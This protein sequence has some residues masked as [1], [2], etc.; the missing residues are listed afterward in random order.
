MRKYM[1]QIMRHQAEKEGFKPSKTVHQLWYHYQ[2]K[3]FNHQQ[4]LAH[5][6]RGT[7]PKRNWK[8]RYEQV[9]G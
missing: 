8:A 4:H 9:F 5:I 3:K 6:A 2:E 7:K 1:R